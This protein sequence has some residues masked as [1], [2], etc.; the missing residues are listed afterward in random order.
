[1]TLATNENNANDDGAAGESSDEEV[2]YEFPDDVVGQHLDGGN[3]SGEEVIEDTDDVG[4]VTSEMVDL[5]VRYVEALTGIEHT[6]TSETRHG[7]TRIVIESPVTEI[8]L[9][10]A[11]DGYDAEITLPSLTWEGTVPREMPRKGPKSLDEMREAIDEHGREDLKAAS[12]FDDDAVSDVEV[13]SDALDAALEGEPVENADG[14]VVARVRGFDSLASHSEGRFECVVCSATTDSEHGAK[15]HYG[16]KHPDGGDGEEPDALPDDDGDDEEWEPDWSGRDATA[17]TDA[18]ANDADDDGGD[19]LDWAAVRD[20]Y[21]AASVGSSPVSRADAR[22]AVVRLLEDM[23]EWMSIRERSTPGSTYD[24]WVWTEEYGW[25]NTAAAVVAEL[26][27]NHVGSRVSDTEV[28][29]IISQLARLNAVDQDETNAQHLDKTLIPVANGVIDVEGIDY[30]DESMTIDW[31]TVEIL[32]KDPEHRFLY[33]VDTEWDPENAD[34]EGL[35]EW[36]ETITRTDEARRIIWEFAGHSLHAR[37]PTDGFA[38]FLGKG[39]SGKSQTLEVIKAMLGSENVAVQKLQKIQENRFSGAYVV[40]KRA[41]INTELSGTKIASLDKLKVYSAGEEDEVEKK[42]KAF[43]R[44]NNDATMMFASD[45]PPALPQ[46]NK[47]VGRRLYPIEFPASYVDDPDPS[48][49]FELQHRSKTEVEAELRADERV[50]AALMRAVEG[51]KRLLEE[52]SGFTSSKSWR[53]RVEQYESFADPV[54]DGARACLEADEDSAIEAGDL[55]L[56]FGAFFAAKDHDGKSMNKISTVI[57]DMPSLPVAKTRTRAFTEDNSKQTVYRGIKFTEKAK[58]NWVPSD[59]HWPQYGGKP[60][61]GGD[62]EGHDRRPVVMLEENDGQIEETVRVT[63]TKQHEE[64]PYNWGYI[65]TMEGETGG[66]TRFKIENGAPLEEGVTYD[67]QDIIVTKHESSK[68]VH[69][70]PGLTD[71][72]VVDDGT[73]D[74]DQ[75]SIEDDGDGELS[76]EERVKTVKNGIKAQLNRTD[77]SGAVIDHVLDDAE[78]HDIDRDRARHDIKRLVDKGEVCKPASDRV[79]PV[80]GG[81]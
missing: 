70:I 6:A 29:H 25:Q 4:G 18:V 28:K 50:K 42:G 35:D 52:E 22:D 62:D 9:E 58:E 30:D 72:A 36:L 57:S 16:R 23:T 79:A 2:D 10:E 78:K 71:Y 69:I 34:L 54:R 26:T 48:N 55:E 31:D 11:Y 32:D 8:E 74:D 47:A 24:L 76:Q 64:A 73:R 3:N 45:D 49:P 81:D 75:D 13:D 68:M 61:T 40:D 59:A 43:Y 19:E 41:N 12:E 5:T 60:G 37:Y 33:Q 15:S 1:M 51:L 65:G 27:A 53:E 7:R 80:S 38:V 77:P 14:T 66:S 44:E 21:D 17:E 67:M 63:V 46:D 20:A 56:T 39:G